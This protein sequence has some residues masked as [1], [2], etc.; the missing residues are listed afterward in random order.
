M[1]MSLVSFVTYDET[2]SITIRHGK[3]IKDE[4]YNCYYVHSYYV[5]ECLVLGKASEQFQSS[6]RTDQNTFFYYYS[7]YCEMDENGERKED[8]PQQ[9]AV[10]LK[11][12][13]Q[14]KNPRKRCPSDNAQAQK[15][16]NQKNARTIQQQSQVH[17]ITTIERNVTKWNL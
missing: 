11:H 2:N 9:E 10:R 7:T 15:V 17:Y 16:R 6:E 5:H 13:L 3:V 12:I 14:E 1:Q 4:F 8:P